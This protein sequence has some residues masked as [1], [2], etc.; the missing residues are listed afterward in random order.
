MAVLFSLLIWTVASTILIIFIQAVLQKHIPFWTKLMI[1]GMVLFF[2]MRLS[3]QSAYTFENNAIRDLQ[4]HPYLI[5]ERG[6]EPF[7]EINPA[8]LYAVPLSRM[9]IL[10]FQD[11]SLMLKILDNHKGSKNI[12]VTVENIDCVKDTVLT[13]SIENA[14][15]SEVKIALDNEVC[16]DKWKQDAAYR[17]KVQNN[18]DKRFYKEVIAKSLI[19]GGIAVVVTGLIVWILYFKNRSRVYR[20]LQQSIHIKFFSKLEDDYTP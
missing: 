2:G 8:S 3:S 7:T 16:S 13:K 6:I 12:I 17:A 19:H 14:Q 5:L 15:M 20:T 4:S 9:S 10:V 11:R 18:I 1:V